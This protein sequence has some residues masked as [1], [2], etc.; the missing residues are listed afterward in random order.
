MEPESPRL[1]ITQ[2]N[3]L[4]RCI[5]REVNTAASAMFGLEASAFEPMALDDLLAPKTR[6]I[7]N[8]ML[9]FEA[10]APDLLDILEKQRDIKFM[11]AGEESTLPVRITRIFSRD[12]NPWFQL[13]ILIVDEARG[14]QRFNDLLRLN[15]ESRQVLNPATGLPDRT[16][17]VGFFE[18]VHNLLQSN[19]G[20]AALVV[21]RMDRY[22]KSMAR[23]GL[24]GCN[25]LLQHL[26][27]SCRCMLHE[28]DVMCQLSDKMLAIFLM[29]TSRES[30][31]VM[32]NRW[33]GLIR[34][35]RI[36]FG[37]KSEF[38]ITVS[39]AF[40]MINERDG[41][42]ALERCEEALDALEQDSRNHLLE[43]TA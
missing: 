40:D 14:V 29:N 20:T 37:G 41:D 32:L 1:I 33:R 7:L 36:D 28:D 6:E 31:R 18:S 34:S 5:V 2:D 8:D 3:A 17:C 12:A 42:G 23:Y 16:T 15:L 27:N 43:P 25:Q 21:L 19:D 13:E 35:H 10:D 24:V 11:L 30:A 4:K 39:I 38:S 22:E 26:A 9:E